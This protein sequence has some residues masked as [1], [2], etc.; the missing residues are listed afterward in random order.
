MQASLSLNMP[1]YNRLRL[2]SMARN[3]VVGKAGPPGIQGSKRQFLK[4]FH[5][6]YHF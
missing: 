3:E 2:R 5:A 4:N 6:Y 1:T